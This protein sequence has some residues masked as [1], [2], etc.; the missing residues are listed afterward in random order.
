M[1]S[2]KE[3]DLI[4]DCSVD[5]IFMK[6]VKVVGVPWKESAQ[7]RCRKLFEAE[8]R[9]LSCWIVVIDAED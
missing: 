6:Y 1:F 4:L 2:Y 9:R 3:I 7:Q 8:T 5:A